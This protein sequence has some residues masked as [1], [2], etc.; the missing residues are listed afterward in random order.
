[1]SSSARLQP[2]RPGNL[3]TRSPARHRGWRPAARRT[4]PLGRPPKPDAT[5]EDAVLTTWA[6]LAAGHPVECPVCGGP[7]TA[8]E[9]CSRCGSRL[10]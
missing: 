6:A 3:E 7:L 10:S 1:M 9:G 8:A 2:R 4:A 5:L